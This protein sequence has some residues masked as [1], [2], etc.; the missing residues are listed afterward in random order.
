MRYDNLDMTQINN[1][2]EQTAACGSSIA[3]D[4]AN[5]T[6]FVSYM[7]GVPKRYGESTGKICLSVFSPSQPHLVRH[8]VFDELQGKSRGFLCNALYV[9]GDKRVRVMFTDHSGQNALY[10]EDVDAKKT[11]PM[12]V[13]SREYDFATDT[14]TERREVFFRTARGEEPI[15]NETYCRYLRENGYEINSKWPPIINKVTQYRGEWYTAITLDDYAFSYAT[16]CKIEGDVLVPFAICPEKQTYEFRYFVNDEG[17]F[18]AFRAAPDDHGTNHAGYTVSRDGGKTWET[19]IYADG[20]QS[21]HDILEYYGK[22]LFIYNYKS[23]RS[24]ENFPRMHNFR[25]ALK[26]VYDGEVIL[27]LFSKHGFVEH[28]TVSIRGE[29][30]MAFSNCPQALSTENGAAWTEDGLSVEQ[31]KETVQW[32]KLGYLLP[33]S[34]KHGPNGRS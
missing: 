23:D 34:T 8:R 9:C 24:V 4:K 17:I 31:G 19:T 6:A 12:A 16:L 30:Y 13:Y 14:V 20:V 22:P 28:D 10:S 18:G 5:G 7:T 29:L 1:G 27:D 26:F 3:Y 15:N 11:A 21:R 32:M 2:L 25:N 33:R